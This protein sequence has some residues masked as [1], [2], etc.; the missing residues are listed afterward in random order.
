M[1][2]KEHIIA[3]MHFRGHTLTAFQGPHTDSMSMT[4]DHQHNSQNSSRR[5]QIYLLMFAP[6]FS[7][8]PTLLVSDARSLPAR[9]TSDSL[10]VYTCRHGQ[11]PLIL[12]IIRMAYCT[13]WL[14]AW[15]TSTHHHHHHHSILCTMAAGMVTL[16]LLSTSASPSS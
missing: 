1:S 11:P 8:R 12:I 14:L 4:N 13:P 6:S 3:L 9:S 15:S 5:T 10:P 16:H 2:V 7:W